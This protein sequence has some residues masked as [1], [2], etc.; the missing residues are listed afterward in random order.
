MLGYQ[1]LGNF[2]VLSFYSLFS[3]FICFYF[4]LYN[5]QGPSSSSSSISIIIIITVIIIIITQLLCM[6]KECCIN[7]V[8][9]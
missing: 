1:F 5:L 4:L 6:K 8:R 3:I 7:L 9:G 2:I